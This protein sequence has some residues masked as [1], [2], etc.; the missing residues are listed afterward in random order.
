MSSV[1]AGLFIPQ[2]HWPSEGSAHARTLSND[3]LK[4]SELHASG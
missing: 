3:A 2:C 4:L 1:C